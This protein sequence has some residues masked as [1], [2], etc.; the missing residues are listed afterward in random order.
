M[1][2]NIIASEVFTQGY[3]I[4]VLMKRPVSWHVIRVLSLFLRV[5]YTLINYTIYYNCAAAASNISPSPLSTCGIAPNHLNTN[6]SSV[7]VN[8]LLKT[9]PNKILRWHQFH[10]TVTGKN[11][12]LKCKTDL[13]TRSDNITKYH[14]TPLSGLSQEITKDDSEE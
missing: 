2:I 10:I 9:F 4:P 7:S 5:I 3:K 13:E 12:T 8:N 11:E 6:L 1:Q 14:L